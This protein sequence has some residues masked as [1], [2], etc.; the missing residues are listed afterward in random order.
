MRMEMGSFK[1]YSIGLKINLFR[2]FLE[3]ELKIM[4]VRPALP[5]PRPAR[6][7]AK[8]TS[9]MSLCDSLDQSIKQSKAQ[10]EMLLQAVLRKSLAA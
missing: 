2:E 4:G 3:K 1:N 6:I 10:T 9:L 8:L 7:V 5:S